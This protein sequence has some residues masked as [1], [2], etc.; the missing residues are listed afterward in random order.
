M[1]AP[2]RSHDERIGPQD[3]QPG[4]AGSDHGDRRAQRLI[5]ENGSDPVA[6]A[7]AIAREHAIGDTA[8]WTALQQMLG[9]ATVVSI[10][11]HAQTANQALPLTDVMDEVGDDNRAQIAEASRRYNVPVAHVEAIIT[12]ESRGDLDAN[13]G[14]RQ[15]DR[16]RHAAS[17]LMQVTE[18]TWRDTQ[19]LHPEL[20]QYAFATHRYNRRVNILVG[21]AALADKRQALS[22]AGIDMEHSQNAAMLTSMAYNAGQALVTRAYELARDGGSEHPDVDCLRAQYLKPAIRAFPSV[23]AYYLTGGGKSRNPRRTVERAVDLK[24]EE[25]SRYP[26]QIAMMLDDNNTAVEDPMEETHTR[27]VVG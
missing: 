24:F 14:A 18:S 7:I 6:L 27:S 12:Q 19:R 10:R 5:Q 1:L 2:S 4:T 9:N 21:T 11:Q 3:A 16:G 20:A 15:R 17:G 26:I 13:A 22:S 8:M 25:I 23:Y